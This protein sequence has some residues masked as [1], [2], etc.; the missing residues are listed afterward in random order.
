MSKTYAQVVKQIE[1]LKS[2]AE[3][4]R[5]KEIRGVVTRIREAISFYG[6]SASDLGLVT[7]G[8]RAAGAGKPGR[9][10][11]SGAARPVKFRDDAGN[12]WVGRGKRPQWLRDAISDGKSLDD[13]LVK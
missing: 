7:R 12:S 9:K 8:P 2:E 1:G 13:F 10:G 11:K 4:L 6:L 3:K 5:R